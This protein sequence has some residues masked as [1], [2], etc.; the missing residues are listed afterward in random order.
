MSEVFFAG[1]CERQKSFQESIGEVTERI[2]ADYIKKGDITGIK[3]HFGEAGNT[4]FLPPHY[5]KP[6]V[7]VVKDSGAYP[8]LFDTNTLYRGMRSNTYNHLI[9]AERHGFNLESVGAPAVIADGLKGKNY[10]E[11][12]IKGKHFQTVRLGGEIKQMDSIIVISHVKGHSSTGFGGAVKN[13]SMGFAAR[14]GKQQMHSDVKPTVDVEKCTACGIC[15]E[16]CPVSA[17]A[18]VIDLDAARIDHNICNGCGECRITCPEG[19]IDISWETSAVMLQEKMA[20]YALGSMTLKRGLIGFI[21]F[22]V[23][24]TPDC[25]CWEWSD[26]RIVRDIGVFASKDPISVDVVSCDRINEQWKEEKKGRNVWREL[27]PE[28]DWT[29]QLR[30]GQEIG[31]GEMKYKVKVI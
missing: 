15:L 16:W 25:D 1:R 9:L 24:I 10:I 13:I 28:I 21:N 12:P 2:V 19:A 4:E 29:I 6:V 20:E 11:V 26:E 8:V 27:Y 7:G 30:Y 17:I 5:I 14:S 18:I 31:V 22:A 23:N 3:V